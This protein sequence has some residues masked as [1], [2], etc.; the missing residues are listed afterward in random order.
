MSS[1]RRFLLSTSGFVIAGFGC[2][3]EDGSSGGPAPVT[4]QTF[5]GDVPGTEM[6]V[7]VVRDGDDVALFFCGGATTFA[8]ATKWIRSTAAGTAF[9]LVADS[10]KATVSIQGGL[11]TGTVDI[12]DGAALAWQGARVDEA[13][14]AG[15]YEAAQSDGNVGVIVALDEAGAAFAQGALVTPTIAA[16]VVPIAPVE[17]VSDRLR[18]SV[19]F[20]DGPKN[21]TVRRAGARE[22]GQ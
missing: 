21:I 13:G 4:Q 17:R 18:V 20:A 22:A 8:T 3:D 1:R 5:V 7:A 15:L 19:L 6:R 10:W 2:G 11:V 12:G 16:Q 14:V 9:D